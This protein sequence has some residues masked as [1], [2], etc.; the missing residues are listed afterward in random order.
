MIV[1]SI[2]VSFNV[3]CIHSMSDLFLHPGT[4]LLNELSEWLRCNQLIKNELNSCT[5]C[6]SSKLIA[7]NTIPSTLG[8]STITFE[9]LSVVRCESNALENNVTKVN[10]FFDSDTLSQSDKEKEEEH[11]FKLQKNVVESIDINIDNITDKNL[12]QN[13]QTLVIKHNISHNAVNELLQILR[14]HGHSELSSDVRVLMETPRN[15]AIN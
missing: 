6:F 8:E 5:S 15:A 9:T 13:L 2:S 1:C 7:S 14:Q 11:S 4:Q 10:L 12:S 3:L